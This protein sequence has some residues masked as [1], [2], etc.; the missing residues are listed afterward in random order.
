MEKLSKYLLISVA[1]LVVVKYLIMYNNLNVK[2]TELKLKNEQL[3]DIIFNMECEKAAGKILYNTYN[4]KRDLTLI[5][6]KELDSLMFTLTD[7]LDIV[8]IVNNCNITNTIWNEKF[9]K[10]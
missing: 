1:I 5:E 4:N 10:Q 2:C 6:S 8:R 7:S 3:K 9:N